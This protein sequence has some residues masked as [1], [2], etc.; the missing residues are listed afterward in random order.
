M[1]A[2]EIA[3]RTTPMQKSWGLKT[4]TMVLA[5]LLLGLSA[6]PNAAQTSMPDPHAPGFRIPLPPLDQMPPDQR[7]DFLR[8]SN[9]LHTPIGPRA[10]LDISPNVK[11]A[12]ASVVEQLHKNGLPEDLWQLTIL[13]TARQWDSQFEWWVHAPQAIK[14]GVPTDVVE[15]IRVGKTPKFAKPGEEAMY[16]YLTELYRDHKVSD[17]TYERLRAIVGTR[18]LVELTEL[19]GYYSHVAMDIAAHNLPLRADVTPPLPAK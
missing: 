7:A 8:E 16:R 15:A 6:S 17:A 1:D 12:S 19:G 18:Q 10:I 3:A 13:I 4:I 9:D 11:A 2:S 5:G 14:A